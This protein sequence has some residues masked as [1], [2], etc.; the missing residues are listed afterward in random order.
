MRTAVGLGQFGRNPNIDEDERLRY[1]VEMG[2][3]GVR[4]GSPNIPGDDRWEYE[5][6]LALQRRITEYGLV[7][8]AIENVPMWF[9]DKAMLGLPGRDQQI[10]NYQ[11]TIRNL[12][13]AGIPILGYHWMPQHVW[14]T[15]P[16]GRERR[17]AQVSA[18]DL[19]RSKDL[20][21]DPSRVILWGGRYTDALLRDRAGQVFTHDRE[22]SEAEL[23]ENWEYFIK[24]VLPVAE[25]SGVV[26]SHHPDDPPVETIGGIGRP[27]RSLEAF[28]RA[29]A[30]TASPAWGLTFC[31][32]TWSE[33]PSGA[34]GVMDGIEY[35]G[36]RN[37]ICYVHFRDVKGTVPRFQ[38][39][40][41]GDG[42]CDPVE[43]LIAL[44]SAGFDGFLAED[45][46][47]ALSGDNLWEARSRGYQLG[48]IQGLLTCLQHPAVGRATSS[49]V[50]GER[51]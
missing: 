23:W 5:D 34:Q 42:N 10:E 51:A 35:F 18:F 13:R 47:P 25:E 32:G 37:K 27:F 45:H 43:V 3:K 6:I 29:E 31:V 30:Y 49:A 2:V 11:F 8:E 33:M 14:R 38:E 50:L 39:C 19:D 4:L 46:V 24:A 16:H 28:K 9:M 44:Q 17:T 21:L 7:I 48:F 1:A 20:P 12:G 40:F 22:Y 15:L 26:L 41:L 36:S